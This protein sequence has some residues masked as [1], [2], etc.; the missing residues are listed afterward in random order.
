MA[1]RRDFSSSGLRGG[2]GVFGKPRLSLR[3]LEKRASTAA[4]LQLRRQC[5]IRPSVHEAV[6]ALR[7]DQRP[8]DLTAAPR[9]RNMKLNNQ[10]SLRKYPLRKPF[11]LGGLK[12]FA[13]SLSSSN[14][15]ERRAFCATTNY[16]G[17]GE[18]SSQSPNLPMTA[19]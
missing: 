9:G 15:A 12:S 8:Q 11:R 5:S 16:L 18:T 19:C 14:Q 4:D 13:R 1:D 10:N 6:A 2:D 7:V 17:R 3:G